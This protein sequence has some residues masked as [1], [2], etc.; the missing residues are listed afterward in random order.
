[1]GALA[2]IA[3]LYKTQV[4]EMAAAMGGVIPQQIIDKPPSA[5][6]RQGQVDSDD[7]PPY[8]ELD[9]LLKEIIEKA[10]SRSALIARG[11]AKPVVDDVI[12]RYYRSEYKRR[13]LPPA[14]KVSPKS[15]GIGRRMPLTNLHRE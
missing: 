12:A 2:P 4:F 9:V 13:Q 15:F 11:F 6:L 1:M 7:L 10:T 14:I 8:S 5:E 3:D